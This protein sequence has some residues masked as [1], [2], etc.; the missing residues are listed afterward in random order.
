MRI[1]FSPVPGAPYVPDPAGNGSLPDGPPKSDGIKIIDSMDPANRIAHL[2]IGHAQDSA[3][4][5]GIIRSQCVVDDVR[6]YDRALSSDG[7]LQLYASGVRALVDNPAENR[8][9]ELKTFLATVYRPLDAPLQDLKSQL[10]LC[11]SL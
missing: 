4:S 9:S 10:G 1:Q 3:G 2:D 7:V 11:I 6:F 5:I 8:T